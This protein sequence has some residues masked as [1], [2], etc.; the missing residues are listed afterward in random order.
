MYEPFSNNLSF[1]PIFE[2]ETPL[3]LSMNDI[4]SP[5]EFPFLNGNFNSLIEEP[6]INDSNIFFANKK[7]NRITPIIS[8]L[9]KNI[10][11]HPFKISN[12]KTKSIHK[13]RNSS[14]NILSKIEV[15]FSKFIKE[16]VNHILDVFPNTIEQRFIDI[17]HHLKKNVKKEKFEKILKKKISDILSQNISS[18]YKHYEKCHNMKLCEEIEK[19]FPIL[20]EILEQ[21][22]LTLFKKV[23]YPSKRVINL[24][25]MYNIDKIIYLPEN[26]E[27][28][29]DKIKKFSEE[30]VYIRKI[31][32]VV[33]KHYFEGELKFFS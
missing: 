14:D 7:T 33:N 12:K 18:K 22:Y 23:Y 1:S 32:N 9:E 5:S 8:S 21:N 31:Q 4:M 10:F 30:D 20:K 16:Y 13:R 28:F 27:M 19:N 15:H 2:H 25:N 29:K 3:D 26:I 6:E 11:N 24:K 17:D